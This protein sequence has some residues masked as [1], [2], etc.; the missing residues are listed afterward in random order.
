M[1][2]LIESDEEKGI[3]RRRRR[4]KEEEGMVVSEGRGERDEDRGRE[5]EGK[6]EMRNKVAM[7]REGTRARRANKEGEEKRMRYLKEVMAGG[8]AARTGTMRRR[9]RE[10]GDDN[11]A[12]PRKV[13]ELAESANKEEEGRLSRIR[14]D[15][16]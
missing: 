12:G 6:D 2:V 7:N 13:A 3:V 1:R 5:E 4:R 14:R 8:R 10:E 16:R 11:R 9:N 15:E